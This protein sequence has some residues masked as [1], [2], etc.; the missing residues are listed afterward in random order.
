MRQAGVHAT[1]RRRDA[2]RHPIHRPHAIAPHPAPPPTAN[3]CAAH[4]RGDTTT[5]HRHMGRDPDRR[6]AGGTT[7][8]AAQHPTEPPRHRAH[9]T[10]THTHAQATSHEHGLGERSVAERA[11]GERTDDE[12]PPVDSAASVCPAQ[13]T[14]RRERKQCEQQGHVDGAQWLGAHEEAGWPAREHGTR[15]G[16]RVPRARVYKG[17]DGDETSSPGKQLCSARRQSTLE[18]YLL[19][20][21]RGRKAHV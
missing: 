19:C 5:P 10:H 3:A 17:V 2:T 20:A 12:R 7:R 6:A 21:M 16:R 13:D 11:G 9:R 4:L 1:R 18:Q 14:A 15:D 8:V